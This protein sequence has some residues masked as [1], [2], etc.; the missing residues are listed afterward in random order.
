MAVRDARTVPSADGV[1][2]T[3][4]PDRYIISTDCIRCG[5]CEFMCPEGAI[6][7]AKRQLIILKNV[8][9]GCGDCVPFCV[10]R[11]IVP[12]AEFRDREADTLAARLRKVL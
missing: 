4:G 10:V 5:V 6:V 11:A 7:E 1:A 12:R 2:V 9:T 3:D 8:C